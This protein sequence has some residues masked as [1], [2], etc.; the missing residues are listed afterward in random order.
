MEQPTPREERARARAQGVP[1][2]P[3]TPFAP[4][5]SLDDVADTP[6][7]SRPSSAFTGARPSGRTMQIREPPLLET[8]EPHEIRV[9]FESMKRYR[10][11][12]NESGLLDDV[13]MASHCG[14]A[15][16]RTLISRYNYARK[17]R[18]ASD[19]QEEQR[20]VALDRDTINSEQTESLL[21]AEASEGNVLGGA[22]LKGEFQSRIQMDSSIRVGTAR[23]DDLFRQ[24]FST[25]EGDNFGIHYESAGMQ[26][27]LCKHILEKIGPAQLRT[28]I[29]VAFYKSSQD[30]QG[31]LDHLHYLAYKK[32][33]EG[34]TYTDN[35]LT[36]TRTPRNGNRSNAFGRENKRVNHSPRMN[37]PRVSPMKRKNRPGFEQSPR[38][39]A[40]C[41][42]CK[43]T[44]HSYLVC[45]DASDE[46]K[47]RIGLSRLTRKPQRRDYETPEK[48]PKTN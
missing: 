18:I 14:S 32:A 16:L 27:Q 25:L 8:T 9:F 36:Q 43:R 24:V 4:M 6:R 40:S 41:F 37:A 48:R 39:M 47:K 1:D 17:L 44:G 28:N 46:D 21:M 31:S 30:E 45:R 20:T 26:K 13:N 11:Q 10:R 34:M 22:E 3:A 7:T 42:H 19:P 38:S 23:M 29:E 35:H 15:M 5:S 33:K 2:T 12:L